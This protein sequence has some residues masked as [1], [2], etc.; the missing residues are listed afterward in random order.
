MSEIPLV[1]REWVFMTLGIMFGAVLGLCGNLVI[2][3][4]YDAYGN[5][6]WMPLIAGVSLGCLITF[7][8]LSIYDIRKLTKEARTQLGKEGISHD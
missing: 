5:E 4:F 6:P 2:T 8:A 7:F 1:D 3:Y